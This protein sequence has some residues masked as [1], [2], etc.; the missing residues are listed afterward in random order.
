MENDE[1]T[2]TLLDVPA[3]IYTLETDQLTIVN[4]DSLLITPA[5]ITDDKFP[6]CLER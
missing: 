1:P 3:K 5:Y 4:H 2:N 6:S